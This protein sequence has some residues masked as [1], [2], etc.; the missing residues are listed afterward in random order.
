MKKTI[1]TLILFTFGLA[2]SNAQDFN[3]EDIKKDVEYLAD[4]K[5]EGRETGTKG[6]VK[7][8]KCIAKRFKKIGIEPKGGDKY[9][10]HFS[11]KPR[12][13][14]PHKQVDKDTID[15]VEGRNVI[16]YI[17]NNAAQTIVIGAH[18]DHLG[19]GASG[20]LHTGEP[21]IHNG[22]DDNASGVAAMI[23]LAEALQA[24]P[25]G[26]N[27][28]FI[29]FSGEEK[30]LWG[31]N[32]Y[33]KN[34]TIPVDNMN[35][36]INMDMVGRLNDEKKLAIN[37]TG[38]SPSFKTFIEEHPM[39][40]LKIV[41]SESGIGPSDHTSF[42]LQD[43]PVLHFFTGQ[44]E[45][46]HKPSDDA[47]KV[48]YE[49]IVEVVNYIY[50]IIEMSDDDGKL[51]F[52]KTK[53]EDNKNTPR[54]KVTLGVVPD[55]LFDGEGMRIDGV[56]EDRPAS[57]AGMMKGDVVVKLGDLE[58]KDMMS[59]MKALSKFEKGDKTSVEF[60]RGDELMTKEIEF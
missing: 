47:D 29:A 16:G 48:N 3:I 35:Y 9:Y 1:L 60:K 37:G 33:S 12:P 50:D 30:G 42:Y 13:D 53:E 51:T 39:K 24:G 59:Y 46:Y 56:R 26:N 19:W 17:D 6:E 4:D 14:N 5:L 38:S 49:G 8:A 15:P 23:A 28:L 25:D 22:A 43:V 44:H 2:L 41:E 36:M 32:F 45:D 40:D 20:S 21:A 7:A 31:S 58:I 18:Y 27:Y 34:S 10:Q 54:F 57:K 11:F 52:S 55:Y